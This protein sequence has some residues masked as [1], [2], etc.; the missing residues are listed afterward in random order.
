[1]SANTITAGATAIKVAKT[2]AYLINVR[3][4]TVFVYNTYAKIQ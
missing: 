2:V 4:A 3:Y 1:M